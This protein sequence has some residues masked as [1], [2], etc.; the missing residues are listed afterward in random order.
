MVIMPEK[1]AVRERI[2]LPS[3]GPWLRL[4]ASSNSRPVHCET[5]EPVTL[6][7]SRRD[8]PL[9]LND[10]DVSKV[11]SAIVHTGRELLVIDLRSRA[12]TIL[13]GHAVMVSP[14]KP[15]DRLRIGGVD[16]VVTE[17]GRPAPPI[18]TPRPP[19]PAVALGGRAMDLSRG[20]AV[21]GRRSTCDIV[22]DTPDVSLAHALVFVFD[23]QPAIYDLGSRSGT[24]LNGQ[25]VL[26]AWL[27]D[28]DRLVIG[29][30]RLTVT[31]AAP[32]AAEKPA[33]AAAAAL[34][35]PASPM[36]TPADEVDDADDDVVPLLTAAPESADRDLRTSGPSPAPSPAPAPG[37]A[38]DQLLDALLADLA[39]AQ[40]KL[41]TRCAELEQ[42]QSALT[43]R[44]AVLDQRQTELDAA[45]QRLAADAAQCETQRAALAQQAAQ[46]QA[47][48][49]AAR[50]K[51]ALAASH[52]QA[53]AA[54]WEE[55]ERWHTTREARFKK[56]WEQ[57]NRELGA[58]S[59]AEVPKTASVA[60]RLFQK[61]GDK[62][63]LT[64]A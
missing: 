58:P 23:G 26:T 59:L 13:N 15:G 56:L 62:A 38:R 16:A 61:R 21:I 17:A 63:R 4:S 50:E 8:C 41:D 6:I 42:Q 27:H 64:D 28:G 18:A 11:H 10:P 3:T 57:A 43:A 9:S 14:L 7:G 36:L 53:V 12:G 5:L 49:A 34:P 37:Q 46:S 24:Y 55:L 32:A 40:R 25:R 45:A 44:S 35:S 2:A 33:Q 52:E 54:A 30:E 1:S 19:A 60:A 51:L 31:C 39:A 47:E 48:L 29:G 20:A 22:L